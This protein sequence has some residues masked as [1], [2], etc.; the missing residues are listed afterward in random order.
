M[1]NKL[2]PQQEQTAKAWLHDIFVLGGAI[3]QPKR[4]IPAAAYQEMYGYT[5]SYPNQPWS[6]DAVASARYLCDQIENR[7][8]NYQVFTEC[9]KKLDFFSSAWFVP[10]LHE[11]NVNARATRKKPEVL[12]KYIA[13][14]CLT[15]KFWWDDSLATTYE[16]DAIKN[17]T[18]GTALFDFNCFTSQ[19]D[20]T[21]PKQRATKQAATTN[22]V[23][24]ATDSTTIA[25]STGP[26]SGYK[27]S[28]PHSGEIPN[29]IGT[30]GVKENPTE[31]LMYCVQA[32]KI[33]KNTP[34]A[35]ITP[36][37][38]TTTGNIIEVDK[39][40]AE[41]VK[42]GSGNGY[43]DCTC[44][45]DN[46][47]LATDFATKCQN[48]F[49]AKYTNISLA[50]AKT[51]QNGYYKV[52]TEFGECYIKAKKLN[53]AFEKAEQ[54]EITEAKKEEN[55]VIS[56]PSGKKL[57]LVTNYHITEEDLDSFEEAL[58]RE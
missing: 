39:A 56:W 13:Y 1:A 20:P 50:K 48:K 58:R 23:T 17:T 40:T 26:V 32:D 11:T 55:T 33:G 49:G 36:L 21:K 28:G 45:F 44:W 15:N 27:N 31:P 52:S 35:F 42:F 38:T 25:Q 57:K 53:E 18:L 8:V 37:N 34:N 47:T 19:E 43:T 4:P 30:A 5:Y 41:T 46:L 24:T 3:S 29:I 54:E 12:A 16:I 2:N 14:F 7:L 9:D 51:D 6:K 22:T 10:D